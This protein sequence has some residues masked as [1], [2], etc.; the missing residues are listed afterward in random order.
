MDFGEQFD[1]L[2]ESYLPI[3]GLQPGI[4]DYF[5]RLDLLPG[6]LVVLSLLSNNA[7]RNYKSYIRTIASIGLYHLP[8]KSR[9]SILPRAIVCSIYS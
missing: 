4:I 7:R 5:T 3:L 9:N 2:N 8:R 1:V 6:V